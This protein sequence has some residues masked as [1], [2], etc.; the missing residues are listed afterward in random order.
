MVAA[1]ETVGLL[2]KEEVRVMEWIY[3]RDFHFL[4]DRILLI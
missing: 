4:I 2:G 3:H 1:G